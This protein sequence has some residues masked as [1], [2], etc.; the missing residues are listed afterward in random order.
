[1]SDLRIICTGTIV[2]GSEIAW[3]ISPL[4][5]EEVAPDDEMQRILDEEALTAEYE[6]YRMDVDWLRGGC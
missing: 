5:V 6:D 4:P 1:M 3:R 2:P